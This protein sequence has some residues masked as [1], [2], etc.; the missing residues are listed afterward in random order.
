MGYQ[1]LIGETISMRGY[2]GEA[3]E[4]YSARPLGVAPV[5]GVVVIHHDR[6]RPTAHGRVRAAEVRRIVQRRR[7]G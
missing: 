6:R 3:I 5:P 7:G 4:A 2:N 1:G